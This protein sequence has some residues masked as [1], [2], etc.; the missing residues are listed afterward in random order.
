M[1]TASGHHAGADG[2]RPRIFEAGAYSFSD[3][4]GGLR[5]ISVSGAGTRGAPIVVTGE[6]ESVDPVALTIGTIRPVQPFG[7][8]GNYAA[9][10][11]PLKIVA[12]NNSRHAWVEFEL[13]LH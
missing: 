5:V 1:L 3:E 8:F 6:L 4:L 2:T 13:E 10:F 7:H 9:G 11:I 12:L